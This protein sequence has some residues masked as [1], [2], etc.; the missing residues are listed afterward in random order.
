MYPI[1]SN[2]FLF[3]LFVALLNHLC[4]LW[5]VKFFLYHSSVKLSLFDWYHIHMLVLNYLVHVLHV[6]E[7]IRLY[8]IDLNESQ[9]ELRFCCEFC[10]TSDACGTLVVSFRSFAQIG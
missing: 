10:L 5:I 9:W 1:C 7:S 3:L 4:C 2:G 8:K 6:V